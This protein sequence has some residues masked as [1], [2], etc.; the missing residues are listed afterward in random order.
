MRNDT[1]KPVS[2]TNSFK[3]TFLAQCGGRYEAFTI[4]SR[5]PKENW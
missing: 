4:N 2:T 5:M 1:W 3:I